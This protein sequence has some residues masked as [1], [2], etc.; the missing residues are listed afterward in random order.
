M[1][2][3][4][5]RLKKL[6]KVD[7][8]L[9]LDGSVLP[10]TL[11]ELAKHSGSELPAWE[12]EKLLPYMRVEG[13]CDSLAQYLEKFDF[14]CAF[15]QSAHAL[16][17]VAYE[18]VKQ[19]AEQN[20]RYIEVRY[21]PQLH[22]EQ[23]LTVEQ[24]IESVLRGLAAGESEFGTV[25][26]CIAIC[27]RG[28]S[29]EQNLEV[30]HGAS[31]YLGR[32]IVAVD[33]AGAEAAYPPELY[34]AEFALAGKLGLPVTI[35]AGEA[36]GAESVETAVLKLGASR[37]GHGVRMKGDA[38]V[39]ELIRSRG[40]P[41]EMCPISNL[42][43]KASPDWDSYPLRGYFDAGIRVTVNTDNLTVSGTT[44][45]KEYEALRDHLAFTDAELCAIVMNGAE[46][47]FLFGEEKRS[48][49]AKLAEELNDWL[50]ETVS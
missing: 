39:T 45:T 43:T 24:T 25:A 35:H 22:R 42:Q 18:L 13:D 31:A 49:C 46:A 17:R 21:A 32:G 15:L 28:H 9:H 20:C 38:E 37:I 1:N 3:P 30:I 14:V 29:R 33:L 12:P 23:G 44:I 47:A 10:E 48:L 27:L 6:P 11:I 8:H 7:L 34:T 36:A 19:C 4:Q 16:E 40:I 5:N 41:L 50:T 26:R 2:K